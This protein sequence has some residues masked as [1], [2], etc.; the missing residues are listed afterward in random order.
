MPQLGRPISTAADQEQS[1]AAHPVPKLDTNTLLHP[2]V[3]LTCSHGK[4]SPGMS[5]AEAPERLSPVC[6]RT[7]LH[8]VPATGQLQAYL[9]TPDRGEELP[10]VLLQ[11]VVRDIWCEVAHKDRMVRATPCTQ[12]RCHNRKQLRAPTSHRRVLL[13]Y[14]SPPSRSA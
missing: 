12:K 11:N 13:E 10:E 4:S 1:A 5:F 6:I 3:Q 14:L 7:Q 9:G 2:A 8:L